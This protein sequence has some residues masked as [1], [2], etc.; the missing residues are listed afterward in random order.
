MKIS[1]AIKILTPDLNLSL[2]QHYWELSGSLRRMLMLANRK[3]RNFAKVVVSDFL[4]F[5]LNGVAPIKNQNISRAKAAAE[6]LIRAKQSNHDNGVSVGY[7]P[8]QKTYESEWFPSYPETTGYIIQTLLDYSDRY[9]DKHIHDQAMEMAVWETQVQMSSGA[10]QGGPLC[11]VE[12]QIAAIFNTGMVLQGYTAAIR[13][14]AE[15]II[16]DG[17]YRAADFLV[18]DL[19]EDGHFQS[20]G[21]FVSDAKIKTYNCLCAWALYRFGEDVNDNKYKQAAIRTTEASISQ[22]QENGW[23]AN[24]CLTRPE[25]PLLHTI[26]YTL[27]GILEV[28]VLAKRDDFID[29]VIRGTDPILLSMRPNGFLYGRYSADWEPACFSS[30]LTGNAQLAIVCYRLFEVTGVHRYKDYADKIVNYLKALQILD[31]ENQAINGAIPGSF[32]IVGSYM[33]LGYPNWATKYFLDSLLL[34]E[35]LSESS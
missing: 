18:N 11:E 17:A 15:K 22:Q 4:R 24:N 28:G 3:N 9:N 27:Q 33:T 5:V 20:H 35:R 30:C 26:G 29:A 12:N 19:G 10:V 25:A 6:W 1:T 14:G 32:P 8:C 34:Q 21:A 13:S 7:F 16:V 2:K 31:S 23:F